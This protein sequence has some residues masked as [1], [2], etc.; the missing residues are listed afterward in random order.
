[1]ARTAFANATASAARSDAAP[2]HGPRAGGRCGNLAANETSRPPAPRRRAASRVGRPPRA[3]R[4]CPCLLRVVVPRRCRLYPAARAAAAPPS[5]RVARAVAVVVARAPRQQPRDGVEPAPRHRHVRRRVPVSSSA[6][7]TS[8]AGVHEVGQCARGR[9][10]TR[11]STEW[12]TA[13]FLAA[14]QAPRRRRRSPPSRPLIFVTR[15]CRRRRAAEVV[16]CDSWRR[17]TFCWYELAIAHHFYSC[18]HWSPQQRCK[19]MLVWQ[20]HANANAA[21]QNACHATMR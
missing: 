3:A 18:N 7:S 12:H 9:S 15:L 13:N 5:Q 17:R 8:M 2:S 20:A 4:R 16:R 21:S 10:C 1:M 14:R 19:I 11:P 6:R